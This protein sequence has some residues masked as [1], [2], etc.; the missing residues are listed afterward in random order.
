MSADNGF[1]LRKSAPNK[2]TLQEYNA[3][4]DE[5]PPIDKAAMVFDTVEAA[6]RRYEEI[7]TS[8]Y[9]VEYGLSVRIK[10]ITPPSQI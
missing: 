4:A 2:Y 10:D 6:L 3:S 1:I 9:T 5:Y 7:E 8:A